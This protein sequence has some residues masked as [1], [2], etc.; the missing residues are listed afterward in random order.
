MTIDLLNWGLKN[1]IWDS[2]TIYAKILLV[3]I[4]VLIVDFGLN[5]L[6][7][8]EDKAIVERSKNRDAEWC[9]EEVNLRQ[10]NLTFLIATRN[11]RAIVTIQF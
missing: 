3:S 8:R 1:V 6:A 5:Y 11:E 9:D 4:P 2:S 7:T 10:G